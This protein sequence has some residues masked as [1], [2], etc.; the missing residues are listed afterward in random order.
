MLLDEPSSGV[1]IE[2]IDE[3][4][5]ILRQLTAGGKTVVVIEHNVSAA[6]NN[7]DAVYLLDNGKLAASGT[8]AEVMRSGAFKEA[9]RGI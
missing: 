6:M 5:R 1:E 3:I 2:L 8:P 9:Y 4:Q 7:S